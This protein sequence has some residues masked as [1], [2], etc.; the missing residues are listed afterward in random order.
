MSFNLQDI[1]KEGI[2]TKDIFS[3]GAKEAVSLYKK[4]F[5]AH[6]KE[7]D[8]AWL[9]H[10]AAIDQFNRKWGFLQSRE[11]AKE[12]QEQTKALI[13]YAEQYNDPEDIE[14]QNQAWLKQTLS[15][16]D[17]EGGAYAGD[18]KTL[19]L[20][21]YLIASSQGIR[22]AED[23]V[24][25]H[26]SLKLDG[27][28]S[29]FVQ[30]INDN[31][32]GKALEIQQEREAMLNSLVTEGI[33]TKKEGMAYLKNS[34]EQ[35]A[36]TIIAKSLEHNE[37]I[38]VVENR[39]AALKDMKQ[40]DEMF[41]S[42]FDKASDRSKT[43]FKKRLKLLENKDLDL[44]Y[45]QFEYGDTLN[46]WMTGAATSNEV[47][48]ESKEY[49]N[50]LNRAK[51]IVKPEAIPKLKREAEKTKIT[52]KLVEDIGK[53]GAALANG[54]PLSNPLLDP[55]KSVDDIM[56]YYGFKVNSPA[57]GL[58]QELR[59]RLPFVAS[60]A[61]L[62]R[63][64]LYEFATGSAG[65]QKDLSDITSVELLRG[66]ITQEKAVDRLMGGK[67][68]MSS[69]SANAFND[70]L[71]DPQLQQEVDQIIVENP[72][73]LYETE[74]HR[75]KDSS[76]LVTSTMRDFV[77]HYSSILNI[78][79][80]D[81]QAIHVK[82]SENNDAQSINNKIFNYIEELYGKDDRVKQFAETQNIG[83]QQLFMA[84]GASVYSEMV[85]G[86][87]Q[88]GQAD[89][90][91]KAQIDR[92]IKLT[93]A[94]ELI[95]YRIKA[96]MNQQKTRGLVNTTDS[97]EL[98]KFNTKSN[99]VISAFSEGSFGIGNRLRNIGPDL[100]ERNV[101]PLEPIEY[102]KLSTY[103]EGLLGDNKVELPKGRLRLM[104]HSGS[105]YKLAYVNGAGAV[106][107][108]RDLD[109]EFI[110]FNTEIIDWASDKKDPADMLIDIIRMSNDGL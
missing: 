99:L 34:R 31:D 41:S 43:L 26:A 40:N 81:L 107:P 82:L 88:T 6:K 19:T 49:L 73:L 106:V 60:D 8:K 5:K 78:S 92:D 1:S 85:Q 71:K 65:L 50:S 51:S 103:I 33:Y 14:R 105:V 89:K 77:Q 61:V 30:A 93:N 28:D 9:E 55:S 74:K 22:I 66:R 36:D 57:A 3:H 72:N 54:Q 25:Q 104:T 69:L 62:S 75:S 11:K 96:L 23:K 79:G 102:K 70:Y 18:L 7:F 24:K 58:I 32:I 45:A 86:L 27:Y 29:Q 12:I 87:A 4:D 52:M 94:G 109:N 64:N 39:A 38:E 84:I 48:K 13:E 67:G 63:V 80:S 76:G 15:L 68:N 35:Y 44:E 16:I 100:G 20:E 83:R 91:L 95:D 101:K 21:G 56:K 98:Q 97:F 90:L 53:T 47:I 37:L 59:G 2:K 110:F 108:L 10:S 42:F 46:S 17:E